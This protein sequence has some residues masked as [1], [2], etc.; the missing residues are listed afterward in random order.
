MFDIKDTAAYSVYF[1]LTST[2]V[3]HL[4]RNTKEDDY[5]Y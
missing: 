2:A 3:H 4:V 5:D 1:P